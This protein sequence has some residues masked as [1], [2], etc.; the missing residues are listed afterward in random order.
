MQ[1][2]NV[3][4]YFIIFQSFK[5]FLY[6]TY[7]KPQKP[8]EA[9]TEKWMTTNQEEPLPETN[10]LAPLILGFQPPKSDKCLLFKIPNLCL[11]LCA[12]LWQPL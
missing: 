1:L 4:R 2:T 3:T 12:L 11:I 10:L 5:N 9:H 7:S 6:F 8:C